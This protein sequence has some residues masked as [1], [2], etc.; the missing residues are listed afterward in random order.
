MTLVS[1]LKRPQP[2]FPTFLAGG[3]SAITPCHQIPDQMRRHPIGTGPFKFVE[4]KPNEYIK[5]TRNPDYWKPDRPYLDAIDFTIIRDPTTAVLAFTI[6]KF[7]V[8]LRNG[9][10]P[11]QFGERLAPRPLRENCAAK[12][13]YATCGQPGNCQTR[14]LP[15]VA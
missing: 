1:R 4:F 8:P 10:L 13:S 15:S 5:L 12:S 9:P 2:A 3:F 14:D 7:D 11:D 6:G